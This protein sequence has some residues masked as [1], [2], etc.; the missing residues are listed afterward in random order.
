MKRL[1]TALLIAGAFALNLQAHSAGKARRVV[2]EVSHSEPFK[3]SVLGVLAV[4]MAGDTLV[5]LNSGTRMNP[6]STLKLVST[7]L[8]L[9]SL[10]PDYRFETSLAYDGT[11]CD[12]TLTGNLYIVGGGDPTLASGDSIALP[13]PRLFAS[14]KKMLEEAGIFRIEG[15][16]VGDGRYFDGEYEH[17]NWQYQDLGTYYA[18]GCNGLCFYRNKQDIEVAAG[19]A[20]GNTVT[21]GEIYPKTPWI[22]YSGSWITGPAG[23]GDKLYLYTSTLSREA[24]MRGTFALDRPAK[25]EECSN[26]FPALTCAYMFSE[27]LKSE[28]IP[29]SLDAAD[30]APSGLIRPISLIPQTSCLMSGA[31]FTKIG[32]T[33][34]PALRDIAKII[35]W[36]SDN[37]YSE[38]IFR[39]NGKSV[40]GSASYEESSKVA[41]EQLKDLGINIDGIR[42]DDGSG[43]SRENFVTPAFMCSFL[44]AMWNSPAKEAFVS[45][46]GRPGEGHY[47]ARLKKEK[48][49]LKER[50]LYKSG[51]MGGVQCFS[52][53]ILPGDGNPQKTITFAVMLGNCTAPHK[54]YIGAIDRIVAAIASEN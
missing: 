6:A 23:S 1:L 36:R 26:K 19:E 5:S 48:K 9:C 30:L 47:K 25:A 34:S 54:E 11:I 12:S 28:G 42:I 31:E 8:A 16:V 14:W 41:I 32:S 44:R 7:G 21:I 27:Y 29:V 49:Q 18:T 33:L 40:S 3:S 37:L 46:I 35:L 13:T 50:I 4:N 15:K 39:A 38:A 10:G 2:K 43:L 53:Y 20:E 45:S 52:G 22:H 17:P 51:S 24:R